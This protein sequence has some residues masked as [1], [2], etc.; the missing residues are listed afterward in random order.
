M[1]IQ[2]GQV[3]FGRHE[4]SLFRSSAAV[5]TEL[6]ATRMYPELGLTFGLLFESLPDESLRRFI[7]PRIL[8]V[9]D[10]LFGG[11]IDGRNLYRVALALI[12]LHAVLG[13]AKGRHLSLS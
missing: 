13:D 1:S 3:T 10:A 2:P 12:D 4:S 5:A 7:D 9:L 8:A 6:T 11:Q